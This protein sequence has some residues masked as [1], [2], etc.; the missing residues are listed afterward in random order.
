MAA[1]PDLKHVIIVICRDEAEGAV[2]IVEDEGNV[3]GYFTVA[4]APFSAGDHY[5]ENHKQQEYIL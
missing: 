5:K 2:D 4:A 1:T 3:I